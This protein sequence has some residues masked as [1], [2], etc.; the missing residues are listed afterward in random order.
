MERLKMNKDNALVNKTTGGKK[1][2]V[3]VRVLIVLITL[4]AISYYVIDFVGAFL[5]CDYKTVEAKNSVNGKNVKLDS[6]YTIPELFNFVKDKHNL[7]INPTYYLNR[8]TNESVLAQFTVNKVFADGTVGLY[9]TTSGDTNEVEYDFTTLST[10]IRN[11]SNF[12][13]ATP[14][15]S[16]SEKMRNSIKEM[17]F[18]SD[19]EKELLNNFRVVPVQNYNGML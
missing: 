6:K 8:K 14:N 1:K 16:I 18:P 4:F 10:I 3:L 5:G 19:L 17:N 2:N 9:F 12:E 11:K 7:I 13:C 15:Y